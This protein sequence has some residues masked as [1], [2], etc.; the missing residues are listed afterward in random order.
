MEKKSRI[1]LAEDDPNFG[2]VLRDYLEL[3][4]FDVT[5]CNNGMSG[6]NTSRKRDFDLCLLDVM[7]PEMDGFTLAREI[8][9]STPEIPFIFLTAKTLKADVV[10]GYRIGADDYITKPFDSEVLLYKIRAILK[11]KH[12]V[13][14]PEDLP[15]EFVVGSYFF[16]YKIRCLK[17]NDIEQKLSPKEAELLRLLCVHIND[18]VP[19]QEAL[20]M[21]WDEDNFFTARSMDVYIV[22]LRKYLKQDSRVEIVNIHGNG[23]RL[24]VN[25]N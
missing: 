18:V 22:K 25:N 1:L 2:T 15:T 7:M 20:R 24:M 16:N 6:L 17:Q 14:E 23:Y 4:N 9:R 21:I 13:Q 11:R 10:E 8:R 3:H 12:K 19:R 5:L